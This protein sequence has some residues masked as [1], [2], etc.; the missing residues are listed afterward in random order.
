MDLDLF[1]LRLERSCGCL[2]FTVGWMLAWSGEVV[3]LFF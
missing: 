3:S 1:F 2:V